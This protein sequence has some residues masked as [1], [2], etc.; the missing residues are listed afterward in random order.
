M[1][2]RKRMFLGI[3]R[4]SEALDYVERAQHLRLAWLCQRHHAT[5]ARTPHRP[6]LENRLHQRRHSSNRRRRKKIPPSSPRRPTIRGLHGGKKSTSCPCGSSP[7]LQKQV[8]G[9]LSLDLQLKFESLDQYLIVRMN[10]GS[11][12]RQDRHGARLRLVCT[13]RSKLGSR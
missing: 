7:S 12:R 5:R 10:S 4:S 2:I 13:L 9:P 8:S 3:R 11:T 1:R 6:R